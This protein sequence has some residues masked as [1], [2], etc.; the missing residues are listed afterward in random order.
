MVQR[1][2]MVKAGLFSLRLPR[3]FFRLL[4]FLP[5]NAAHTAKGAVPTGK[6][7]MHAAWLHNVIPLAR[8]H[9]VWRVFRFSWL[10]CLILPALFIIRAPS[11]ESGLNS[12]EQI[13]VHYQ[14]ERIVFGNTKSTGI[15]L[16]DS[17][18][19]MGVDTRL[20]SELTGKDYNNF[21][22][23]AWVGPEGYALLFDEYRKIHGDPEYLFLIFHP[24][25]FSRPP[26]WD[27]WVSRVRSALER[28]PESMPVIPVI[29]MLRDI[30]FKHIVYI[31][32]HGA[33]GQFYGSKYSIKT[34]LSW[35]G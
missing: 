28:T 23:L 7:T 24:V 2:K 21:S 3:R 15:F 17:S 11:P 34:M 35:G 14:I 13:I 9:P 16:G 32:L 5:G 26:S 27:R 19:L 6:K 12:V 33:Y 4:T 1:D 20:L 18:G 31:P 30:I 22:T 25:S 29:Y 8:S 10:F